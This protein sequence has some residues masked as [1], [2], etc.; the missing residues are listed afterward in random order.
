MLGPTYSP[1]KLSSSGTD[2]PGQCWS[3]HPGGYLKDMDVA[4]RDMDLAVGGVMVGGCLG[5]TEHEVVEFKW[6]DA[7]RIKVNRA[8]ALI[9]GE[10]TPGS[11][12]AL[13]LRNCL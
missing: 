9:A 2:C 12:G 8:A 6:V 10:Q 7:M 11:W 4:L 3:H 1:K 5:H 13:S